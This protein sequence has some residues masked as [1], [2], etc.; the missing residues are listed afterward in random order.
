MPIAK[1][2][3]R[4][5]VMASFLL[6]VVLG[7]VLL[8]SVR[9]FLPVPVAVRHVANGMFVDSQ[10]LY[11]PIV[12]DTFAFDVKGYAKEYT[13]KPRYLDIYEIGISVKDGIDSTYRFGGKIM[14]EFFWRERFLFAATATSTQTA[15]Y[16]D[17]AMRYYKKTSLLS[18][19][20]PFQGKYKDDIRVK[21]TVM[22]PDKNLAKYGDSATLYIGISATP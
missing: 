9:G 3:T 21:L 1:R 6:L 5:I 15:W 20:L 7:T 19:E 8:R 11:R 18:F 17:R 22:E 12:Q 2:T 14:A 10:S 16:K 4:I 13:L